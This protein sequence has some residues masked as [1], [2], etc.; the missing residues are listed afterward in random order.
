MKY[1]KV[2]PGGLS[3]FFGCFREPLSLRSQSYPTVG[4]CLPFH[5]RSLPGKELGRVSVWC[6]FK[7][8]WGKNHFKVEVENVHVGGIDEKVFFL[9]AFLRDFLHYALPH[10]PC[11]QEARVKT[12]FPGGSYR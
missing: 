3:G 12:L 5:E 4:G 10:P 9:L 1:E 8:G 7:I 2:L 11:N 6:V